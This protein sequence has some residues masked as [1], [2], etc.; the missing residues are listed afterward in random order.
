VLRP[1]LFPDQFRRVLADKTV[2]LGDLRLQPGGGDDLGT[3]A[4]FFLFF[5]VFRVLYC[6]G[7]GLGQA[8]NTVRRNA[9]AGLQVNDFIA[10][11][12]LVTFSSGADNSKHSK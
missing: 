2:A 10:A 5:E 6:P 11:R 4:E 3:D 1:W 9:G 7:R 8:R 12:N